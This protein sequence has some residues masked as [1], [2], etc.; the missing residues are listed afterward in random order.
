MNDLS[1]FTDWFLGR[2]F[3]LDIMNIVGLEHMA[4]RKVH[5]FFSF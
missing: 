3:E 1:C 5:S 4:H 2:I